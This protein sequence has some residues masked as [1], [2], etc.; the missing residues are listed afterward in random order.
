MTGLEIATKL[1]TDIYK[2]ARVI[3]EKEGMSYKFNSV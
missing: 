3:L 2:K 1:K